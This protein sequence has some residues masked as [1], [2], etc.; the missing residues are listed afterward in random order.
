MPQLS[1]NEPILGLNSGGSIGVEGNGELSVGFLILLPD[2]VIGESI[3]FLA[4]LLDRERV[5]VGGFGFFGEWGLGGVTTPES[6][7]LLLVL[8]VI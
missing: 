6:T 5:W 7:N 1:G 8:I 2:E 3:I 4:F